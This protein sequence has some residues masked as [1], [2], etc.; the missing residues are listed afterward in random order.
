MKFTIETEKESDGRWVAEAMEV[1]GAL[2]Y[3]QSRADATAK[4][5][6]LA[7]RIVADCVSHDDGA[8]GAFPAAVAAARKADGQWRAEFPTIPGSAAVAPTRAAAKAAAK[9]RA[10][11]VVAKRLARVEKSE[12][13]KRPGFSAVAAAHPA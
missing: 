12:R 6:A 2:V 5:E 4:A 1:R 13:V 7:L 10:L 8:A 9:A 3:G 11:E